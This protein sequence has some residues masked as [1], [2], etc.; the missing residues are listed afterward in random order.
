MLLY[1][2]ATTHLSSVWQRAQAEADAKYLGTWKTLEEEEMEE[3]ERQ[4]AEERKQLAAV[5]YS[6]NTGNNAPKKSNTSS[7]SAT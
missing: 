3:K 2:C 1:V 7:E 5:S 6:H 4:Q